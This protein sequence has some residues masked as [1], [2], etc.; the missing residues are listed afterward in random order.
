MAMGLW[1]AGAGRVGCAEESYRGAMESCGRVEVGEG[2]VVA[3]MVEGGCGVLWADCGT[4]FWV[5]SKLAMI[6]ERLLVA[7]DAP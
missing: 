1:V 5:P 4:G 3:S 2:W 7:P 6:S